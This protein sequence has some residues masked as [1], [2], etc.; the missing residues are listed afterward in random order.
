PDAAAGDAYGNGVALGERAA[1]IGARLHDPAEIND[2]GAAYFHAFPADCNDN[3][4]ADTCDILGGTSADLDGDG[5]PDECICPDSS[6][7]EPERLALPGDPISQKI[8][9]LSFS[10]GDTGASQAIRV[11]FA[12]LPT[13]YNAWDG[14]VMWVDEPTTFCENA[15]KTTPPCPA[16]QPSDEFTAATLQC[17]PH[18]RDWS[19]VGYFHVYHEGIIPGGRYQIQ[20]VEESCDIGLEESYSAPL[21]LTM[22]R[23]GDLVRDCTTCP[24]GAPD[25]TVGIPTDVTAALDKFKNLEPPS[26]PCAAVTKARADLDWETPNQRVDI[27]DVTFSLDAF[28]GAQYPPES[29]SDPP[30]EDPCPG[31]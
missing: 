6:A 13:A 20:A 18:F 10:A 23:W 30:T 19:V 29:F 15:G 22:S 4:I 16:A 14:V 7:P 12:D 8:R 21:E 31:P 1:V 28:R 11:T 2:A 9:Y 3:S 24:C 26:I 5:R 25:G 17:E 27:S